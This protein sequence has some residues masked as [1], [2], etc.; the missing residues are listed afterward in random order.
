MPDPVSHDP[1]SLYDPLE[2]PTGGLA[3]FY[4][5]PSGAGT[6]GVRLIY[7]LIN[8]RT[9]SVT[10]LQLTHTEVGGA[11][12]VTNSIAWDLDIPINSSVELLVG[13]ILNPGDFLS[14]NASAV[15]RLVSHGYGWEMTD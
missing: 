11:A 6:R 3:T 5:A 15:N 14:H 4:T 12:G 1:Q 8:N 7:I 9:A 10:T 2:V 13:S